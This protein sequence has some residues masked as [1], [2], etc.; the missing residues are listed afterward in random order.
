[1]AA[2]VLLRR[3]SCWRGEAVVCCPAITT[4][5]SAARSGQARHCESTSGCSMCPAAQRSMAVDASQGTVRHVRSSARTGPYHRRQRSRQRGNTA[6]RASS[7]AWWRI[8][9]WREASCV[10]GEYLVMPA[11]QAAHGAAGAEEGWRARCREARRGRRTRRQGNTRRRAVPHLCGIRRALIGCR[12]AH[13]NL[14]HRRPVS[15]RAGAAGGADATV[16][17]APISN[18]ATTRR[19]AP[20]TT[21]ASAFSAAVY[22]SSLTPG[23]TPL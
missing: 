11:E 16:G 4:S 2:G 7:P 22:T 12:I 1:M 14:A 5:P 21:S 9:S 10:T 13:Q 19:S 23:A 8:K 3:S 15:G 17:S 18:F 6:R 20:A